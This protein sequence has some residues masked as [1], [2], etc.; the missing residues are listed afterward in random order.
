LARRHPHRV[1]EAVVGL[2]D[3][4]FVEAGEVFNVL[5][6]ANFGPPALIAFAGQSATESILPSFGQI[7]TTVTSSRQAQIGLR[8]SF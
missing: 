1:A 4:G 2:I 8:W 5:G 3:A 7:R 6:R